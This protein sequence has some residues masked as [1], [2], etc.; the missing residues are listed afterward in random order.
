[1]ADQPAVLE[2]S[3]NASVAAADLPAPASADALGAEPS[4]LAN[5]ANASVAV[6]APALPD[7]AEPS[8]IAAP[9]VPLEEK[10]VETAVPQS[11]KKE[12]KTA[13]K[14]SVVSRNTELSPA[15][16]KEVGNITSVLTV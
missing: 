6:V 12:E 11:E 2:A 16:I 5:S 14:T 8:V 7:L 15:M 10:V 13:E 9:A 1:M 3:A 4:V